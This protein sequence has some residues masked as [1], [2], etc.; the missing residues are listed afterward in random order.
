[1]PCLL[2]LVQK[3]VKKD[4]TSHVQK[5]KITYSQTEL[6]LKLL[7]TTDQIGISIMFGPV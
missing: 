1:M 4:K 6:S 3:M 7:K 2:A 5:L